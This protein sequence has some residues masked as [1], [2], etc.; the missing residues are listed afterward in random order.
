MVLMKLKGQSDNAL[1][2]R[3]LSWFWV[4][5]FISAVL[6][7][8]WL[9]VDMSQQTTRLSGERERLR[10]DMEDIQDE[11]EDFYRD[12]RASMDEALRDARNIRFQNGPQG[13][14]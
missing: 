14:E 12:F 5:L 4:V 13:F 1:Y 10:S 7:L 8:R 11:N 6:Y 9:L 3:V 2:E